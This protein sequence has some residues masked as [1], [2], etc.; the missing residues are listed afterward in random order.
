MCHHARVDNKSINLHDPVLCWRRS[1]ESSN[2]S[3]IHAINSNLDSL[4]RNGFRNLRLMQSETVFVNAKEVL[5]LEECDFYHTMDLPEIGLV[6]GLFDLRSTIGTYLGNFKFEKKR[7]LEIGTASG[8]VCFS[9]ERAGAEVIAYDLSPDFSW[10][11]VPYA[12][13]DVAAL[14][15][16]RKSH[17]GRLNNSFW[18]AH[19]K[20]GSRAKVVYGTVYQIPPEI[21]PVDATIINSVLLHVRDPF[22]AIQQAASLAKETVIVTD[23]FGWGHGWK[24][25]LKNLMPGRNSIIRFVPNYRNCSKTETWWYLTPQFVQ[26]CL[27]V[28]GFENS[29]VSYHKQLYTNRGKE[30]IN[31]PMFTIVATRTAGRPNSLA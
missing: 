23:A 31:V 21:G 18:L 27:G 2:N 8:F 10:D 6:H 11:I 22:L 30:K 26:E 14:R 29:V 24:R 5:S 1:A 15:E 13:L 3:Y 9:V 28:L 20:L 7:V 16:A 19:K 25:W 12:K 4:N 17:I